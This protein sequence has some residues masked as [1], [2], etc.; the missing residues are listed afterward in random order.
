MSTAEENKAFVRHYLDAINGKDKTPALCNQFIADSDD[1]LK[2]HIAGAEAGFPRYSLDPEDLIAEGDKVILRFTLRGTH[3]GDF[4]GLSPTG[5]KIAVPGII[6][7]RI[8]GGKIAQHWIQ[9][10]SVGMLQQL[11]AM[12]QPA[13]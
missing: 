11:G 2:Q 9:T 7:Y 1:E 6:I 10:D 3:K 4:M 12:P 5:K 13:S 8:A